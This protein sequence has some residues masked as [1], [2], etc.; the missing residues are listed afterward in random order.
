MDLRNLLVCGLFPLMA[1]GSPALAFEPI[2]S[3]DGKAVAI[4]PGGGTM[5]ML[6]TKEQTGGEFGALTTADPADSGPGRIIQSNNVEIWYVLEGTYEFTLG[7]KTYE[8]GPETFVDVDA[9]QPHE[10]K[11]QNTGQAVDDVY[12]GRFRTFLHGLG[13]ARLGVRAGPRQA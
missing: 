13:E 8:G 5:E 3:I 9:G 11:N 6:A 4:H 12:A 10:F 7:D 1:I 2:I